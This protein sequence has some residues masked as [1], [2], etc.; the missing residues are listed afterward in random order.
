MERVSVTIG[1]RPVLID[2]DN[3]TIRGAKAI[4]M[5]GLNIEGIRSSKIAHH[6][7]PVSIIG[8]K[9]NVI[10]QVTEVRWYKIPAL[11]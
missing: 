9:F 6:I 1:N 4:E 11:R 8:G 5:P 10:R 2:I 3:L 7:L